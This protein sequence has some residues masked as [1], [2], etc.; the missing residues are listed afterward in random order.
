V[1]RSEISVKETG[2]KKTV[3]GFECSRYIVTW[4]V[5]TENIETKE[6]SKTTMTNDLWNTPE[7]KEI[8]TLQKEEMEYS[9]AYMKKLGLEMSPE[10]SRKL[11][12]TAVAACSRG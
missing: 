5:E 6:R 11:G 10:D 1:I 9:K 12:M 4:L 3:N 2:E 7:T 8:R